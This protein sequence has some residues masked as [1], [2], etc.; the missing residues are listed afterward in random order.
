VLLFLVCPSAVLSRQTCV[1]V[2]ADLLPFDSARYARRFDWFATA[3]DIDSPFVVTRAESAVIGSMSSC[4]VGR[5]PSF[6]HGPGESPNMRG[7]GRGV[8][9]AIAFNIG[10]DKAEFGAD[11]RLELLPTLLAR[12]FFILGV[13]AK[14]I[15]DDLV[16][17]LEEDGIRLESFGLRSVVFVLAA[18]RE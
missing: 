12:T 6:L 2:R 9:S 1:P 5:E 17:D 13:R 8:T 11:E 4:E 14:G 3:D 7:E 16:D 15:L 10:D 18:V